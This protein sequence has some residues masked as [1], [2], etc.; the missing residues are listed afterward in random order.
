MNKEVDSLLNELEKNGLRPSCNLRRELKEL[1]NDIAHRDDLEYNKILQSAELENIITN[2]KLSGPQKLAEIKK[3][4]FK[5]RYPMYSKAMDEFNRQL[6]E[7]KISNNIKIKPTPF[8][9]NNKLHV[10][11]SYSSGE[12]IDEIIKSMK[13]LEG[14]DLIENAIKTAENNR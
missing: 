8:F 3:T 4:L 6:K 13:K 2:G 10:E 5:K 14:I 12:K 1:I 7:L 9:E 11:F